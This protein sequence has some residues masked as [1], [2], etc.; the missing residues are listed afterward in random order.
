MC[1]FLSVLNIFSD[2]PQL[3]KKLVD[4]LQR[5]ERK[6]YNSKKKKVVFF[7]G[8]KEKKS[9]A[10]QG[11]ELRTSWLPDQCSHHSAIR[12]FIQ[13]WLLIPEFKINVIS[14][15]CS[16]QFQ[17]YICWTHIWVHYTIK[18]PTLSDNLLRPVRAIENFSFGG[19]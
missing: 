10:C 12:S 19:S 6:K 1:S 17:F 14:K 4:L 5:V 13:Y 9:L 18:I 11:F 3:V 15:T 8:K 7:G 16:Q 2:Y